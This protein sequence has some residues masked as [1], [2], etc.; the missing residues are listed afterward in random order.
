MP[1]AISI[2]STVISALNRVK[3]STD[4]AAVVHLV[5]GFLGSGKTSLLQRHLAAAPDEAT[6]I[7]INEFGTVGLDHRLVV[8]GDMPIR[9]L[10]DGCLCCSVADGLRE[11]LRGLLAS[12][13]RPG[14]RPLR[15][16][17]IET[18]GL[19][20]PAPIL[21]TIRSDYA[22][23][24]YIRIGAVVATLDA[25]NGLESLARFPEGAQQLCSADRILVTKADLVDAARVTA[26]VAHARALNSLAAVEVAY[27][28]NFD[29]ATL[30]AL[31]ADRSPLAASAVVP[32]THTGFSSFSLSHVQPVDWARF[33]M[34]LTALLNR[35]GRSVLRFKG[36]LA[37]RDQAQPVV[38]HGVQHLMYPPR[39]LDRMPE[40]QTGSKMVFIV[41]GIDPQAIARSL[42]R[43]LSEPAVLRAA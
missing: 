43:F 31:D 8:A 16:L 7:V 15:R 29:A 22:L 37:L 32:V 6:A 14:L 41:Q 28:T 1:G 21:N 3:G 35:H 12:R 5:T 20:C 27:R 36:I 42:D 30:F 18:S 39:H 24:E 26:T 13:K 2:L 33:S 17:I 40:G 19:A 25:V 34:W 38:L 10:E 4:Q 11:C 9:V 23:N